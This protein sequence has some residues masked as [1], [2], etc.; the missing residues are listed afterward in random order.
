MAFETF[1]GEIVNNRL[2]LAVIV[3]AAFY[4]AFKAMFS[5]S[6]KRSMEYRK[7]I[8]TVLNADEHKV[9]GKFE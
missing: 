6:N 9:K 3:F 1:F 2:F 4:L 5:S 7:E 8:D